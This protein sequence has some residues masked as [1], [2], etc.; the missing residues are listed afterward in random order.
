MAKRSSRAGA[1]PSQ[2]TLRV[3][4]AIRRALADV[5]AR[6]DLHDPDLAGL[7]ITVGEVRVSPDLRHAKVHVSPLGGEDVDRVVT[8]LDRH[9]TTLRAAVNRQVRLKYSP[10]LRFLPDDTFDRMDATRALFGRAASG[11]R[12]GD[13]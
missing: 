3:G 9:Q 2:R 8:A 11:E 5:L 7:S 1:G 10:E 6:G 13:G 12:E 4:E